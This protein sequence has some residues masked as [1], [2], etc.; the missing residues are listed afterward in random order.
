MIAVTSKFR[1]LLAIHFVTWSL[2]LSSFQDPAAAEQ[3]DVWFGTST[4]EKEL[5]KGIYHATF[6]TDKGILTP[7][8]LAAEVSSPKF[9]AMHPNGKTLYAV[10]RPTAL[11]LW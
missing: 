7:P 9:L 3:I 1:H 2:L 4:S 5:S 10:A 6:D 8:T 11:D